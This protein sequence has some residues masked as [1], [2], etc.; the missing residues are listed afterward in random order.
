VTVDLEPRNENREVE[1][2]S[3]DHA[4]QHP[5]RTLKVR[6][7]F[8]RIDDEA[9]PHH[10]EAEGPNQTAEVETEEDQ[11]T[12]PES[13]VDPSHLLKQNE[14]RR[15]RKSNENHEAPPDDEI[16]LGDENT[17]QVPGN[18]FTSPNNV[19]K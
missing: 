9:H 14:A 2:Q 12:N 17:H 8:H 18:R 4:A 15:R 13:G 6:N 7:E 1:L 11:T 3:D 5:K 16:E 19:K 10:G